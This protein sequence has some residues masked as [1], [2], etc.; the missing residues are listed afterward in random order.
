MA[1][2]ARD[3]AVPRAPADEGCGRDSVERE[4]RGMTLADLMVVVAGLA[5]GLVVQPVRLETT[6]VLQA[7]GFYANVVKYESVNWTAARF[8]LPLALA[9]GA[10]V[11]A[12]RTR[13]GGMPRPAEWLGLVVLLL[14]LDPVVPN[15]QHTTGPFVTRQHDYVNVNG[16]RVPTKYV[17]SAVLIDTAPVRSLRVTAQET[18]LV[19]GLALA[20]VWLSARRR[21]PPLARTLLLL[22]L[23]WAWLR[24]PVRLNPAEIVDFRYSWL[25]IPTPPVPA[26]WSPRAFAW[27]LEAR[28][29]LGRWFLGVWIAATAAA[30]VLALTR[31]GHRSARWT[32]WAA[33]T[34]ALGLGTAW[35]WDELVR[36]PVPDL[37]VRGSVFAA[38]LAAVG[39][40]GWWW[41]RRSL[42]A[43]AVGAV[44]RVVND[45]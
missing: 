14:L 12:R 26:G 38:W 11:I 8:A 5:V 41:A 44:P 6:R 16:A 7:C 45:R 28:L 34:L 40:P 31:R 18:A 10:A 30:A 21:L 2:E 17:R 9:V 19:A 20:I 1:T 35:A 15:D 25:T 23:A 33:V 39:V 29:A 27:Y 42:A 4:P 3:P 24:L 13:F 43:G 32:E 36:R 37:V 22:G